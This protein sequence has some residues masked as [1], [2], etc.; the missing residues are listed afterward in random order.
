M[1][2][3]TFTRRQVLAAG[4]AILAA[5][6]DPRPNILLFFPD[7][8]RHDWTSFTP[9]LGVRTPHL[10]ALAERGVRFTN[11]IVPSPLCAPSRACLASGREY[12]SCGVAS[13]RFDYPVEQ[14]T[15]Y[16][17]L[18]DAGYHV[19]GCGKL[20]LHKKTLDW[21]L[22]GRRLLAEWGFSDGI[23]NAGK[24]DAIASGAVE[25]K[26]PYMALLHEQG[27]ARAHVEDF[28]KR[29][30]Y[31]A[32]FPTPLPNSAYCDNW[33]GENG[34]KLLERAPRAKPW[35]LAVN[36]TGPH[37][38]MDI[39]VSM[40]RECRGHAFPQ[41][42]ENTQFDAATHTA[43]RQNYSAMVENLD[44]WLG[45]Y[46]D[47]LR[48]RGE[49]DKTLIVVSS[50]HGEMLGDHNRWA[51]SVPWQP[52]IGVPLV[53][54]G[55]GVKRGRSIDAPVTTLDLTATFLDY[56]RGSSLPQQNSLSM[57]PLLEGRAKRLR[58]H[59]RSGLGSWRCAS[60]GRYKLVRGFA[61]AASAASDLLFDLRDDAVESRNIA[62][63]SP[64]IVRD[65]AARL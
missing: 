35:F 5:R 17:R 31:S 58:T 6:S 55:P 27:L 48:S 9:R 10:A 43:I 45:R 7:Q 20:D 53:I 1:S 39:T 54:A 47:T 14:P 49:L 41:P 61:G 15:M 18:R 28:R 64:E 24:R 42:F 60:D 34:L 16:R 51:K 38:P 65:L 23:D 26:D 57:R 12:S 21:G 29:K 25:P 33:V 62:D 13:N 36:F 3:V 44:G 46:L 56:G 59:V 22:D 50:D 19:M 32:T 2:G 40:E 63:R 52:S 4:P 30:D 37:E 8:W 11:A